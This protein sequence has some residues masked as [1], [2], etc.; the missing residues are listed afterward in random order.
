MPHL[1]CIALG[2]MIG[3]MGASRIWESNVVKNDC[4]YY[5]AKT[6]GFTWKKKATKD[7]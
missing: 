3:V 7:D 4:A 5:D 6:A 1:V 2:V